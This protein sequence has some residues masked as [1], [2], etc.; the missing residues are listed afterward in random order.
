M[1]NLICSFHKLT[2]FNYRNSFS[3][4]LTFSIDYPGNITELDTLSYINGYIDG[5]LIGVQNG[6]LEKIFFF[7]ALAKLSNLRANRYEISHT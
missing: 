3:Y 2:H 4:E 7:K 1:F 6:F 5:F